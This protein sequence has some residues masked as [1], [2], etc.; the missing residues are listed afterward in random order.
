MRS[1]FL[2]V[3]FAAALLLGLGACAADPAIKE[4]EMR[5]RQIAA[6]SWRLSE[7][8]LICMGNPDAGLPGRGL[9]ADEAAEQRRLVL[10]LSSLAPDVWLNVPLSS[11]R[12]EEFR[13]ICAGDPATNTPARA[14]TAA[15]RQEL[16]SLMVSTPA[17]LPGVRG[18]GGSI[19]GGGGS[20]GAIIWNDSQGGSSRRSGGG[21]Y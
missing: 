18:S 12:V 8:R 10:E 11:T 6:G 21:G 7:L 14:L 3:S 17:T 20:A 1:R 15:E 9:T 13:R 2:P 4:G 16:L 19:G 5:N